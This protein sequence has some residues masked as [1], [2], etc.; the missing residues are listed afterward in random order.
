[1][2]ASMSRGRS[3]DGDFPSAS[4]FFEASKALRNQQGDLPETDRAHHE[5]LI[6][7]RLIGEV[8]ADRAQSIAVGGKPDRGVRIEKD[9]FIASHS[10][11]IGDMMSPMIST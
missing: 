10:T 7:E 11:S 4:R 1:M 2:P 5:L 6:P 8:P 3:S 9:H